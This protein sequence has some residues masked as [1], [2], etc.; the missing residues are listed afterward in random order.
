MILPSDHRDDAKIKWGT[1]TRSVHREAELSL[2]AT[3]VLRARADL[4]LRPKEEKINGEPVIS[5]RKVLVEIRKESHGWGFRRRS[6]YGDRLERCRA[7]GRQ[8]QSSKVARAWPRRK[9]RK[10]PKLH[11]LDPEQNPILDNNLRAA[12]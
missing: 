10:P 2:L 9:P 12:T 4:A 5:P 7:D 6:R 3:R 11:T 1:P 8:Q